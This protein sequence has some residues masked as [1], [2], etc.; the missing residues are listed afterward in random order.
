MWMSRKLKNSGKP[1]LIWAWTIG[2]TLV[3]WTCGEAYMSQRWLG[4]C[5]ISRTS[6]RHLRFSSGV[7]VRLTLM[8]IYIHTRH[9]GDGAFIG[10]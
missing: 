3:G 1:S 2:M 5:G 7:Y 10:I 8:W 9:S 4:G 6:A